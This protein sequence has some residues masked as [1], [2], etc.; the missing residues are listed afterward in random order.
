MPWLWILEA[1]IFLTLISAPFVVI[2]RLKKNLGYALM[3]IVCFISMTISYAILDDQ[4][5]I[6]E[7][8]KIFNMQKEY[9]IN[10]QTNT[11]VRAGAFYFGSI[12]GFMVLECL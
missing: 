1:D 6:F 8:T 3:L 5:I 10:Y 4:G 7:P 11:F 2:F 9:T 12:F